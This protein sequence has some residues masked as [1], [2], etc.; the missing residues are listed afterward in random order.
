MTLLGFHSSRK[1]GL[2]MWLNYGLSWDN[3][4][5]PLWSDRHVS[6][7]ENMG[8]KFILLH[9]QDRCDQDSAQSSRWPRIKFMSCP[10]ELS[11]KSHLNTFGLHLG[12]GLIHRHQLASLQQNKALLIQKQWKKIT[13]YI[14]KLND[15]VRKKSTFKL[16]PL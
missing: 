3:F 14:E 15:I 11:C 5:W 8:P 6:R 10:T 16:A 12:R 7:A 9:D 2:W 13:F 4:K 1:S